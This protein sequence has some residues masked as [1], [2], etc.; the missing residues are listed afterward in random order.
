MSSVNSDENLDLDTLFEDKK[1]VIQDYKST[2]G[3]FKSINS[4]DKFKN[5]QKKN[6][7]ELQRIL[8]NEQF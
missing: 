3:S 4:H 6:T 5:E 1:P 8:S 2:S 7:T